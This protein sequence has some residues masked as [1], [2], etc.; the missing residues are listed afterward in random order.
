MAKA[1]STTARMRTNA[2]WRVVLARSVIPLVALG[3]AFAYWSPAFVF[4]DLTGFGDWQVFQHQW[5]ATHTSV[6]RHGEFPFWNPWLCGGTLNWGDPQAQGF[7]PIFWLTVLPFGP[8]VGLKV[9]L[10]LHAAVG[11]AGMFIAARRLLGVGTAAG[12]AAA[13]LWTGSGFFAW[14]VSGGH[15]AF[16]P[17]YFAPWLLITWRRAATDARYAV[18]TAMIMALTIWEGGV[19][20]FPYFCL[21]LAFDSI[22]EFVRPG[23]P[24]ERRATRAGILR[25]SAITIP[26]MSLLGAWR[27]IPILVTMRRYPRPTTETVALDLEDVFAMLTSK[28]YDYA[29]PGH[30]YVWA[31]FGTF[32]GMTAFAVA[33]LGLVVAWQRGQRRIVVGAVFFCAMMMG[34]VSP[35]HPWPLLHHLPIFGSLRVPSRFAVITTLYLG[36]AAAMGVE[37]LEHALTRTRLSR[38]LRHAAL[39]ALLLGMAAHEYWGNA[40]LI[41]RW[42]HLPPPPIVHDATYYIAPPHFSGGS[43]AYPARGISGR[44]CYTGMEYTAAPGLWSGRVPQARVEN[45]RLIALERTT[46][47]ITLEVEARAG[48][49]V[50]VNQT[51]AVGWTSDVGNA[52]RGSMGLVEI[53]AIPPGRSTIVLRFFPEEFPLTASTTA[54][55][56]IASGLVLA[57]ARRRAKST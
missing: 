56:F 7:G 31:E 4:L 43:A 38:K 6:L 25:A 33:M 15:S 44:D 42:R 47:T 35:V 10:V 49:R 18:A 16:L 28:E 41:D 50:F 12:I 48:A 26:L 8:V 1:L 52:V 34:W 46:N 22:C 11:F 13:I 20:P 45:G 54:L 21:L 30:D 3:V 17:F 2:R 55:G 27:L 24:L 57:R 19:Y 37:W 40:E 32:I 51:W 29:F 39:G 23:A 53:E 9:F 5:G 14:H 36:F